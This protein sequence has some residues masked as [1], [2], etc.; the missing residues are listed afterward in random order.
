M[1][2]RGKT[3]GEVILEL[4]QNCN[5]DETELKNI[6]KQETKARGISAGLRLPPLTDAGIG[7]SINGCSKKGTY[8]SMYRPAA[9]SLYCLVR[10]FSQD[11]TDPRQ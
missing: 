1:G 9:L 10:L 7:L 4:Q 6:Q 5:E 2:V 11:P 3:G 8:M